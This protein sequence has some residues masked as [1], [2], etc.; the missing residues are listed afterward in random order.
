MASESITKKT[1]LALIWE[2]KRMVLPE[3]AWMGEKTTGLARARQTNDGHRRSSKQI[4][5]D[6]KNIALS[7][8]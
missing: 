7:H 5:E 4:P 1:W 2:V 8:S 3:F 6:Q